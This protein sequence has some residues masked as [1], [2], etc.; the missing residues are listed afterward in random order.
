MFR[1]L[2]V[3][4]LAVTLFVVASPS[5]TAAK[6]TALDKATLETYVRHLYV[7]DSRI[8]V[9]V[10]DPKPSTDLPGY[11]E[12]AVRA[13]MGQQGQEFKFLISKDGQKVLQANVYDIA[14]NPFKKDLDKLKTDLAPNMGTA[15]APVVMVEFSDFQCPYCKEEAT[16]LRTNLL[17]SYPKQVHLYFK[18]FPLDMHPWAK[19]AAI[20]S[21]CINRQ[22]GDEFWEFHDWIFAHQSE[23]TPENFKEK[24]LEWAKGRKDLDAL[25]LTACMDNKATA[26]DVDKVIAEGKALEIGG[27]STLFINGRRI[28][29]TIDWNTL[30]SIIDNEIEYQKTAKNAGEDCGCTLEL[31]LP[32]MPTPQPLPMTPT[33][34]N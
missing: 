1:T 23:V 15:G 25:Q 28:G 5:Q 26:P 8:T 10:G 17:A 31:K 2:S 16:M 32:G 3:A 22:K 18:T 11:S 19:P 4:I 21:Q 29:T 24:T 9:Q 33:K 20:A 12:V 14:N 13:S 7:L 34:K 27:T 30:R 6:K